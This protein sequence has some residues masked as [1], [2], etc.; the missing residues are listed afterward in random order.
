MGFVPRA[1]YTC[2]DNDGYAVEWKGLLHLVPRDRRD[3]IYLVERTLKHEFIV[4]LEHE[5]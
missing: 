3:T 2:L 5:E 4:H 1:P